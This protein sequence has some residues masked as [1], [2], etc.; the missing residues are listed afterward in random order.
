[1]HYAVFLMQHGMAPYRD[2]VDI[3]MPGTYFVSWAVDHIFGSGSLAWRVFDF[4]LDGVALAA[5]IAIALPYDW[6]AGVYAAA[7]LMLVHGWDG[8]D[9]SGQRDFVMAVLLLAAF[10]FL[11]HAVRRNKAWAMGLFGLCAAIAATIKPTVLPFAPVLLL[12]ACWVL[13]RRQ[14]PF[15]ACLLHGAIGFLIPLAAVFGFLEREHSLSAFFG[16]VHGL[17]P[18]HASLAHRSL[19]YLLNHS[20]FPLAPLLILWVILLAANR[21]RP[22]WERAALLLAVIFGLLSFVAQA[23]GY[24]YHR[25]PMIAFLLLLMGVDFSMALRSPGILRVLGMAGLIYGALVLAPLSLRKVSR[26]D[27]QRT[28]FTT[29]LQADLDSLG[30]A[31]LSGRVQCMDT[32]AGCIA[33]LDRMQLVQDTGFLYDCYFYTPERKTRAA[34]AVVEQMRGKFWQKIGDRPPEVFV[35]SNQLCL[36]GP[37][38]Y[39]KLHLWPQFDAYLAANYRLSAERNP[40]RWTRWWSY[41]RPPFGYRIYLRKTAPPVPQPASF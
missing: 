34:D 14:R 21:Q 7:L 2:V 40:A 13:H 33:T 41:S 23:K 25:Y 6:F 5:M 15:A 29:M 17:L 8:V 18:Y 30:G 37:A 35:V 10:T 27:F 24:P 28:E 16:I 12:L 22:G 11:F 26:Y 1:M 3:N 36:N 9:Q 39:G 31:T 38:G 32:I 20:F 19:G 4:S